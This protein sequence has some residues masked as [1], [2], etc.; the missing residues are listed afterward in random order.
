MWRSHGH[1]ACCL[2]APEPIHNIDQGQVLDT[3]G[4]PALQMCQHAQ[5][6][7]PLTCLPHA[8][9][10]RPAEPFTHPQ[11][12]QLPFRRASEATD[13]IIQYMSQRINPSACVDYFLVTLAMQ[14]SPALLR[15]SQ[16]SVPCATGAPTRPAG[17]SWSTYPTTTSAPSCQSTTLSTA[18][19]DAAYGQLHDAGQLPQLRRG[20]AFWH[21][22]HSTIQCVQAAQPACALGHNKHKHSAASDVTID[23]AW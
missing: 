3:L 23:G 2:S 20:R 9:T 15:P 19:C 10:S 5:A 21:V 14:M 8:D 13:D 17:A 22:S 6:L 16:Q 18:R 7:I 1:T 11:A 12:T 4:S